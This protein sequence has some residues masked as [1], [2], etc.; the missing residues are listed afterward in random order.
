MGRFCNKTIPSPL[1]SSGAFVRI[2]FLSDAFNTDKGFHLTFNTIPTVENCG[3]LYT[4]KKDHIISP[5]FGIKYQNNLECFYQIRLKDPNDRIRITIKFLDLEEHKSCKFD[6]L[7]LFDGGDEFSKK[8]GRYCSAKS[9][10]QTKISSSNMMLIKFHTDRSFRSS[11]FILEYETF[12]G[13]VFNEKSGIIKSTGYPK[14]PVDLRERRCAYEI[15]VPENNKILIE[16]QDLD[17][18]FSKNCT[19]DSLT[20]YE[21]QQKE[22]IKLCGDTMPNP[23][24]SSFNSLFI[25]LKVNSLRHRGFKINYTSIEV[26]CGGL[27]QTS[28][29]FFASPMTKD[30]TYKSNSKCNW[31]IR[32]P[33]NQVIKLTFNTFSIEKHSNCKF[34]YVQILDSR[35][36]EIGK[37]CGNEQPPMIISSDNELIIQFISD[38]NNQ[39][40]GFSASY[41]FANSTSVCGGHLAESGE[42]TSPN[43]DTKKSYDPNLH[44]IWHI[45]AP[46]NRQ[47]RLN[48]TFLDIESND[49]AYDKIEVHNGPETSSPLLATV[50]G[51][52]LPP[53]MV[54]H[55]NQLTIV[56]LTDSNK[57][58]KGFKL[59]FDTALTGCGGT[60]TTPT[61]SLSSPNY[62]SHYSNALECNYLIFVAKGS[63]INLNFIEIDIEPQDICQYDYVELFDGHTEFSPKIGR[64]CNLN[65]NA[66]IIRSTSNAILVRFRSDATLGKKGFLLNYSK[67]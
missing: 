29:G 47:I 1:T 66:G 40:E 65:N 33:E 17:I 63:I 32:S 16:F 45:L 59:K 2:H 24:I 3:G 41:V 6:Y 9:T 26:D 48:F 60:I 4:N 54:S 49:C 13:F 51:H 18:E 21:T 53:L 23:F 56:F 46:Q 52:I 43:F 67:F 20:I 37:Y 58:T 27:L 36:N 38:K 25:I 12:C 64:Y 30:Q 55:S 57:Q 39:L 61:G 7:E 62:P 11:G 35:F 15:T 44:C 50:C 10:N 5:N 34:D 22:A 28:P 19:I 14:L 31:I 8:I 42:I